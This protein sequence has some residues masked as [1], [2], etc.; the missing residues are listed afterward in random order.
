MKHEV[1]KFRTRLSELSLTVNQFCNLSGIRRTTAYNWY[2]LKKPIEP[3]E[4]VFAWFDLYEE[5]NKFYE[6]ITPE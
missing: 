1:N 4:I 2:R 5:L 3:L 6:D